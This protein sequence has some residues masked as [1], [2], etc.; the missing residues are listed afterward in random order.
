MGQMQV[1]YRSIEQHIYLIVTSLT[2]LWY[3]TLAMVAIKLYIFHYFML[4]SQDLLYFT[5][6]RLSTKL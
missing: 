2:Q 3:K 4:A 1:E 5:Q 6:V